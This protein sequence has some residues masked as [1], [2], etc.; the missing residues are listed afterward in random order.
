MGNYATNDELQTRFED[1]EEVAQLTDTVS[2]PPPSTPD[3]AVLTDVI[4]NAEGELNSRFAMIYS[5]PVD[6][7]VDTALA[8]LLKRKT[9]D[10]AEVHL[11]WRGDHA[12]EAKLLQ[13]NSALEWADQIANG[14][15][16]LPGA[17]TPTPTASRG[18]LSAWSGSNRTLSS[19]SP[20]IFTRETQSRL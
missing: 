11:L 6:V 5:T 4:E 15:L 18:P 8:A 12:S 19:S 13:Y 20:R 14:E 2:V 16:A 1:V 9:L 10:L 17:V 7:S 3:E